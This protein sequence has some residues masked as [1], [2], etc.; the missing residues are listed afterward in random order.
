M[1]AGVRL[2]RIRRVCAIYVRRKIELVDELRVFSGENV[3]YYYTVAPQNYY[4]AIEY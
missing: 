2:P 1:R 3:I 4:F